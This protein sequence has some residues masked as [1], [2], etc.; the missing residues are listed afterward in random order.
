MH[1]Q[2]QNEE[3]DRKFKLTAQI[4]EVCLVLAKEL[5]SIAEIKVT[6]VYA[7]VDQLASCEI[8]QGRL[9]SLAVQDLTS[10]GVLYRQVFSSDS[11]KVLEIKFFK[12]SDKY[13][14]SIQSGPS[15]TAA[16]ISFE[17]RMASVT[18]V[19]S[20]RFLTM[21]LSYIDQFQQMQ[22]ILHRIRSAAVGILSKVESS[23]KFFQ[24][25]IIVDQP[26]VILPRNSFSTDFVR[27]DLGRMQLQ[28]S[29]QVSLLK[30]N[31][32]NF[33]CH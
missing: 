6:S 2:D 23:S 14:N 5:Q 28:N 22:A 33:H 30:I 1:K 20:R 17:M 26:I 32:Y 19:H 25:A 9:G 29:L 4:G 13:Y 8:F 31:S 16:Q 21:V 11:E 27:I 18:Y 15:T 24:L 10:A 3:Q 12:L 7:R